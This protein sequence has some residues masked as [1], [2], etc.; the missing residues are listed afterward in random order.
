MSKGYVLLN[1]GQLALMCP[2]SVQLKH[3]PG[4]R[5]RCPLP[6]AFPRNWNTFGG[7]CTGTTELP[8]TCWL[9]VVGKPWALHPLPLSRSCTTLLRFITFCSTAFSRCLASSSS[10]TSSSVSCSLTASQLIR[11]PNQFLPE[12]QRL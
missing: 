11:Q 5:G 10:A 3:G 6:P 8:G 1:L 7:C 9:Y 2:I 12:L 4:T